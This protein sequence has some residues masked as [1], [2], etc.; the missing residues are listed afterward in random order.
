MQSETQWQRRRAVGAHGVF[1]LPVRSPPGTRN[2]L[3]DMAN[4]DGTAVIRS[5]PPS[6]RQGSWGPNLAIMIAL[7]G[8]GSG[9]RAAAG[10]YSV[11]SWPVATDHHQAEVS[12]G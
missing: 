11:P 2:R 3:D 7:T 10:G 6:P 1:Q 5:P 12:A 4:K 9:R 8:T